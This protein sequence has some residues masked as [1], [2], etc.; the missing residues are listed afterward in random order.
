MEDQ[1]CFLTGGEQAGFR[2]ARV[3]CTHFAACAVESHSGSVVAAMP[4]IYSKPCVAE[5]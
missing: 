4:G 2:I 1:N 3:A 5:Y